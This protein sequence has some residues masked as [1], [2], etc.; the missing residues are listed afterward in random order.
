LADLRSGFDQPID[1]RYDASATP[2]AIAHRG[3]AALATENTADAFAISYALGARYLETDV[4]LTAD[5]VPVLFHDAGLRRLTGRPGRI[6][7]RRLAEL[8]AWEPTLE[9]V[10]QGYPGSCFTLDIKVAPATAAIIDVVQRTGSAPRLC[11]AGA[12]DGT[13][14]K[15]AAS[16]GPDLSLAMG[17]RALFALVTTRFGARVSRRSGRLAAGFAHVPL[18]LGRLPIFRTR[19]S[20]ARTISASGS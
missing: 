3:G 12:W 8:P 18:R 13:L 19:W 2:I 6:E 20:S 1:R 11:I 14:Q 16:I 5:G 7:Q 15:M 10:V 17:W 9:G 4:R